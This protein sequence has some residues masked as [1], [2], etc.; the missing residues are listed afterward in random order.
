MTDTPIST[1]TVA[2]LVARNA[3]AH[4]DEPAFIEAPF[5]TTMTWREY[6]ELSS[7]MAAT[8]A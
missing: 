7:Q 3:R 2:S 8:L 6:D 1:E 5:G 4:P